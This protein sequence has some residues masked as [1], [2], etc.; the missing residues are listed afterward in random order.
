[1]LLKTTALTEKQQKVQVYENN[2]IRI[3]M[4]M[5]GADKRRMDELRMEVGV[6]DILR[7]NVEECE[8]RN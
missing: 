8:M 5:N 6:N 4:G 2:W 1:M 3:I 7:R